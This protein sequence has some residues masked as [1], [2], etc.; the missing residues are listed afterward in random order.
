LGKKKLDREV[1]NWESLFFSV[2]S[3]LMSH[4]TSAGEGD[5]KKGVCFMLGGGGGGSYTRGE[6]GGG[7]VGR[8]GERGSSQVPPIVEMETR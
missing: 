3:K 8:K 1:V 5:R 4:I 6:G 7:Q 2:E